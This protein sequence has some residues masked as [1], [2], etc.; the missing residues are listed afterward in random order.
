VVVSTASLSLAAAGAIAATAGG[1]AQLVLSASG[2]AVNAGTLR[3]ITATATAPPRRWSTGSAAGRRSA[4][5]TT[6]RWKATR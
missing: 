2:T 5:P 4:G 1:T 3:D 6:T